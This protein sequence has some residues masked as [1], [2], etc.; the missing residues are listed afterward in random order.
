L[1][2]SLSLNTHTHT[3]T[4]THTYRSTIEFTIDVEEPCTVC[5]MWKCEERLDPKTNVTRGFKYLHASECM[6]FEK[7]VGQKVRAKAFPACVSGRGESF[8]L[9]EM[10]M[11]THQCSLVIALTSPDD[12]VEKQDGTNEFIVSKQKS[13]ITYAM[14]GEA[15]KKKD[16]TSDGYRAIITKQKMHKDGICF[17][18]FEIYGIKGGQDEMCVVCMSEA[19]EVAVLPCRYV[20]FPSKSIFLYLSAFTLIYTYVLLKNRHMCLC[21]ECVQELRLQSSKC[22]ICRNQIQAYMYIKRNDD[23][24]AKVDEMIPTDNNEA[25]VPSKRVESL[26]LDSVELEEEEELDVSTKEGGDVELST[27]V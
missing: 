1:C 18:L 17:D 2:S 9:K 6:R 23:K 5:I 27:I 10:N 24:D 15:K 19:K 13:Q 16:S 4:H 20:F 8:A 3:H 21:A 11:K 14:V 7:G 22:P 12:S 25:P 26:R